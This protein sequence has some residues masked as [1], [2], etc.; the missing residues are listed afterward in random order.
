VL[1]EGN[2]IYY[3]NVKSP[4]LDL[5]LGIGSKAGNFL[6][7][8]EKGTEWGGEREIDGRN[9]KIEGRDREEIGGR[10]R[11]IKGRD[12]EID[13]RNRKRD[14]ETEK[15]RDRADNKNPQQSWIAQLVKYKC[16]E[17]QKEKN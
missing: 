13:W 11:K 2:V 12:R 3:I 15:R 5:K 8:N 7:G 4:N 14:I 1:L 17:I 9:R 6:S 16:S 10:N